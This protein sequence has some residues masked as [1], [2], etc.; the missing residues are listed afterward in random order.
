MCTSR[1]DFYLCLNYDEIDEFFKEAKSS[2]MEANIARNYTV[3][4]YKDRDMLCGMFSVVMAVEINGPNEQTIKDLDKMTYSKIMQL[5]ERNNFEYHES[6][7]L[8]IV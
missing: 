7:F 4:I 8:G 3:D 1:R 2:I 5:C 6:K